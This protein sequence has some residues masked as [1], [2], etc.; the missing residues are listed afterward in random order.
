MIILYKIKNVV[1]I[2]KSCGNKAEKIKRSKLQK[3]SN[4]KVI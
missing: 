2:K 3:K 4:E 1:S